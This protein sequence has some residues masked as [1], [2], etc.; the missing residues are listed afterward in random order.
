LIRQRWQQLAVLVAVAVV[1][2]IVVAATIWL[3]YGFRY[4]TFQDAQAG[5]DHMYGDFTVDSLTEASAIGPIVR[6][7]ND[8]HLLPEAYLHG[9]AY[10]VRMSKSRSAF[11][12]GEYSTHGWKSFFPYCLLVK[13]PLA[14][15]VVLLAAA[16][17]TVASWRSRGNAKLHQSALVWRRVRRSL[18]RTAPIW[19]FLG[20]YWAVAIGTHLNIGHRHVLPTYPLM[21]ILC[22][23]AGSWFRPRHKVATVLILLAVVELIIE[24]VAIYPHYLA[25]FNQLAGGPR[26]GY[27]H[28]V[29]SSLDW[30]QDLPGLKRWLT[31][32][33]TAVAGDRP[34]YLS[35]FGTGSPEYYGIE[36]SRLPGY[37][38]WRRR[39]MVA[40]H[41]GTYCVSATMLACVYIGPRGAWTAEY[42]QQYWLARQ[43]VDE[44]AARQQQDSGILE[45]LLSDPSAAE[46]LARWNAV[47]AALD[48]LRF[49][50]LCAYLRRCEPIDS[51]GYSILIYE[52]SERELD[53][54]QNRPLV[55]W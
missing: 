54:A 43:A 51:V 55:E 20:I 2:A 45:R 42:E 47:F 19:V 35:Y 37:M 24:S 41:P 53:L 15:F 28:L 46:E 32:R 26:H 8:Q 34:V 48:S 16:A 11:M 25:Y 4:A 33:P 3:F 21:F 49:A 17:A 14:T 22:G 38:D 7:A 50:R 52:L 5:R 44:L 31:E 30:G 6:W 23:A 40:I 1:H 29:D 18:Y 39:E 9:F 36:A 12:N 10:A 27:R 13:T